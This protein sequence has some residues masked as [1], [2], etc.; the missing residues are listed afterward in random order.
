MEQHID[1]PYIEELI[2]QLN[3][4]EIRKGDR[5]PCPSYNE[6]IRLLVD[7]FTSHKQDMTQVFF[8]G[9][10]HRRPYDGRFHEKRRHEYL[11]LI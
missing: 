4:T 8:L 1:N 10:G 7:T 3:L 9:N 2:R 5:E 11:Q 6:G